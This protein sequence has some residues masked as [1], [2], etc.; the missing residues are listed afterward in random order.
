LDSQGKGELDINDMRYINEQ[1][2]Y[3]YTDDYLQELIKTVGGFGS[4]SISA[5]RYNKIID[6]KVKNRRAGI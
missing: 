6:K 5:D 3:G 4:D 1:L 2:K